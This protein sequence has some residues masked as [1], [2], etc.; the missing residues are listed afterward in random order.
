M[1]YLSNVRDWLKTLISAD[2]YYIGKLDV[3]NDKSIGVYQR[4]KLRCLKS[5]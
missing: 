5:L 3:K 4:K 2:F 1:I